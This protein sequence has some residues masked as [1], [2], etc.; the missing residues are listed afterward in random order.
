MS[1]RG[2]F[3]SPNYI[4]ARSAKLSMHVYGENGRNSYWLNEWS[5]DSYSGSVKSKMR[6]QIN[7]DL[8]TF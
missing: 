3:P 8:A 7:G 1:G 5:A 6:V 4:H 2:L